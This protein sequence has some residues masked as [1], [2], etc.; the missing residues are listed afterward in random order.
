MT[1]NPDG[2]DQLV[3]W[4]NPDHGGSLPAEI[5]TFLNPDASSDRPFGGIANKDKKFAIVSVHSTEKAFLAVVTDTF[6][7]P[8]VTSNPCTGI[9]CGDLIIFWGSPDHGAYAGMSSDGETVAPWKSDFEDSLKLTGDKCQAPFCDVNNRK[10]RYLHGPACG[11]SVANNPDLSCA[12]DSLWN[13]FGPKYHTIRFPTKIRSVVTTQDSFAVL[14]QDGYVVSWGGAAYDPEGSPTS[15]CAYRDAENNS[16]RRAKEN[17]FRLIDLPDTEKIMEGKGARAIFSTESA[18]AALT[19]TGSVHTWGVNEVKSDS[20]SR[21]FALCD[22]DLTDCKLNSAGF[23]GKKA[24]TIFSTADHFLMLNIDATVSE[25]SAFAHPNGGS[26]IGGV[27]I[28]QKLVNGGGAKFVYSTRKAF[29]VVPKTSSGEP[30]LFGTGDSFSTYWQNGIPGSA[31]PVFGSAWQFFGSAWPP[32]QLGSA[33]IR[34]MYADINSFGIVNEEG[35]IFSLSQDHVSSGLTYTYEMSS[36]QD[37]QSSIE[38]HQIDNYG[39]G[40]PMSGFANVRRRQGDDWVSAMVPCASGYFPEEKE[41]KICP[42][43]YIGTSTKS[44]ENLSPLSMCDPCFLKGTNGRHGALKCSD[45]PAGRRS[46][47][48]SEP[49]CV[50]CGIGKYSMFSSPSVIGAS[51]TPDEQT[52]CFDCPELRYNGFDGTSTKDKHDNLDDC[53]IC[54]DGQLTGRG[55]GQVKSTGADYCGVCGSG[56]FTFDGSGSSRTCKDCPEGWYE[57]TSAQVTC[58]QCPEGYSQ[59]IPAQGFCSTCLPGKK[60]NSLGSQTC[61]DCPIGQYSRDPRAT[62]CVACEE[63]RTASVAGSNTCSTCGAGSYVVSVGDNDDDYKCLSCDEGSYNDQMTQSSCKECPA[64]YS[65]KS[66]GQAVCFPW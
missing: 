22:A 19:N 56:K 38:G 28:P 5:E 34:T 46:V 24:A 61:A 47:G 7:L 60:Q 66:T 39:D 36:G 8:A 30:V 26:F 54:T 21:F 16:P 65:Q 20:D 27:D 32:A 6:F 33:S 37:S 11:S 31:W 23:V 48:A 50:T 14:T 44:W 13:W 40:E 51:N 18:F 58:K 57:D 10:L 2:H 4:G 55:S 64:G 12:A 43:G 41:C 42:T 1:S 15:R 59:D 52:L 62:D 45:C 49:G 9:A 17:C 53:V 3:T 25:L 29:A 63:G 35:K